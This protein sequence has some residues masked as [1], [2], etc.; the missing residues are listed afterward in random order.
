MTSE[1]INIVALFVEK[2]HVQTR[3]GMSH[4]VPPA[5]DSIA[6]FRVCKFFNLI[7]WNMTIVQY[8]ENQF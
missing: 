1:G 7:H 4:G 8:T 5:P 3:Q 2:R 6:F